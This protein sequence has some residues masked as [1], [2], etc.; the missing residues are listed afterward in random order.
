MLTAWGKL[1]YYFQAN[2]VQDIKKNNALKEHKKMESNWSTDIND[3]WRFSVWYKE[4]LFKNH[5]FTL[6][7]KIKYLKG[8]NPEEWVSI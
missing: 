4:K 7:V 1:Y 8:F 2:P 6:A 3:S 5:L